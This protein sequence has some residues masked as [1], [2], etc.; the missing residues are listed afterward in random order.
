MSRRLGL[1]RAGLG[2]RRREGRE[3]T[4]DGAS[5]PSWFIKSPRVALLGWVIL[6]VL[7]LYLI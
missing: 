5:R 4:D 1:Q 6:I 3:S 2:D 7:G